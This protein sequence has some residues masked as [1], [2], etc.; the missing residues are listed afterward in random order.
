MRGWCNHLRCSA[1]STRIGQGY[2]FIYLIV[3]EIG[4]NPVL[5]F[6]RDRAIMVGAVSEMLHVDP[7]ADPA[8]MVTA[9]TA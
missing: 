7:K 4:W 3:S 9:G 2:K 6:V 1:V 8:I 5:R